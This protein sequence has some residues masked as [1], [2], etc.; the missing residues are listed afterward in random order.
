MISKGCLVTP[1]FD[2]L[3]GSADQGIYLTLSDPYMYYALDKDVKDMEVV[4]ILYNGQVRQA[5]T[6]V[7]RVISV[8]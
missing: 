5:A 2:S 1:D 6:S 4:D 3:W 7:L 8:D